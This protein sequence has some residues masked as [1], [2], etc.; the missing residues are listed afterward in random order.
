MRSQQGFEKVKRTI[1]RNQRLC[2]K[3]HHIKDIYAILI[4]NSLVSQMY[5]LLP[6]KGIHKAPLASRKQRTEH[7]DL[8]RGRDLEIKYSILKK[9][10]LFVKVLGTKKC[11]LFVTVCSSA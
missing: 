2:V 3:S 7:I 1:K 5:S 4:Q 10:K 8:R 9:G 6:N 11:K